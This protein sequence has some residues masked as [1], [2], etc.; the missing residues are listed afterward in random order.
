MGLAAE[1]GEGRGRKKRK[2]VTEIDTNEDR[3]DRSIASGARSHPR[4]D[5]SWN[6]NS[7]SSPFLGEY[8]EVEA[9]FMREA[10]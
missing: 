1:R 9:P 7:G 2:K 8:E 5:L 6:Q 10:S 4:F 3:A